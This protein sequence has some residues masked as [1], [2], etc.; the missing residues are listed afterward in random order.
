MKEQKLSKYLMA[1]KEY[2]HTFFAV[3]ITV[4]VEHII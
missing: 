3:T 1:D 2:L 4:K